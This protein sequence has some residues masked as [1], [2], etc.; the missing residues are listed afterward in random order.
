[1]IKCMEDRYI[2]YN[3]EKKY[4]RQQELA[5]KVRVIRPKAPLNISAIEKDPAQLD[6]VY[7]LGREAGE[8][9]LAKEKQL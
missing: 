5:G 1:M 8:E 2:M 4:V 6:R 7:N 9:Y 3:E